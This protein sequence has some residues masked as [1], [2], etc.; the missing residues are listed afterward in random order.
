M[1]SVPQFACWLLEPGSHV[2]AINHAQ[3]CGYIRFPVASLA[4]HG[5]A[6]AQT[7]TAAGSVGKIRIKKISTC[8]RMAVIHTRGQGR[9][10][11]A[12]HNTV[13]SVLLME[14]LYCPLDYLGTGK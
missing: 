12:V 5:G 1:G 2:G 6:P 11:V 10:N 3:G 8:G 7:T 14:G 4:L 9:Y 13:W